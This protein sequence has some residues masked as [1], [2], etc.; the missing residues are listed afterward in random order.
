[1]RTKDWQEVRIK[2]DQIGEELGRARARYQALE[3]ER[4]ALE[5][6]RRVAPLLTTLAG[7]ERQLAELGEVVSLP[8]DAAE[9]LAHAEHE[10][11]IETQALVLFEKQ[12]AELQ[13]K[14]AVLHP[15][16]SILARGTDIDALAGMRQ[17]LRNFEGDIGKR[18]EEIRVLWQA[19]EESTRQLGWPQE[20]ADAVAQRL[21]GSLVRSAI[22]NLV[23]RHETLTQA[24]S[25]AEE[26]LRSRDEE[27]KAIHAEIAAMP[28]TAIPVTLTAAL[29]NA[30][31]LGDAVAQEKRGATQ[32]GRLRRE[33]EA[34]ALELG[35]WNPG[36]D[37]LRKLLPPTGDE[38]NTADQAA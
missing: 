20:S 24:L 4:I 28:A 13:E 29:A 22:G 17:Q 33:L 30:R 16:Q 21:P 11:A 10:V 8:E 15:A 9:Q 18:E 25:T 37:G 32:I 6:V 14:I 38:T 31:S 26:N 23:R 27:V 2:V 36:L 7:P 5:R 19:V 35:E 1:M 12:R 34:M 3:Q